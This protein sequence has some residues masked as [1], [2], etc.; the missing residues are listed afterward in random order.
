M[1]LRNARDLYT[2]RSEGVSHLGGAAPPTITASSPDEKDSF[3]DPAADKVYRHPTFYDVPDGGASTCERHAVRTSASRPTRCGLGDDA[4][5]LAQRL[6]EWISRRARSSRRTSRSANIA[7]DLLGQARTLLHLRRRARGRRPRP[8]TTSPTCATS[9]SSATCSSSSSRD[10]DFARRDG[11]AAASSRPT[12]SSCTPRCRAPP[13]TTLAG[14]AGQGGQGGRLP[15]RPRDASGCCGSA[16]APTSRTGGCRP[17]LERVWPYV[18]ELF[19]DDDG[20]AGGSPRPASA[21][22]PVRRCA[23]ACD[24]RTSTRVARR[25]DA[26]RARRTALALPAAAATASTPS[27]WATCSPRCSTSPAPT[28]GR[29]GDRVRVAHA[30]RS[31]CAPL[32]RSRRACPTPR[33]RCITI[34]RPRHPARRHGRRGRRHASR[35]DDHPDLLRLPGHGGHRATTSSTPRRRGGLTADACDACCRRPGPPTG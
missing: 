11:P 28:R 33:C 20:R 2:R 17:A 29:R 34:A 15:P 25:G 31:R 16:T 35:V 6:G 12:S 30:G 23:P 4:L 32:A 24:R 18:D 9:A 3:F 5:V 27:R 13:T 10:G 14:V 1:A 26:D 19:D 7:L 22:R 21:C 8:R